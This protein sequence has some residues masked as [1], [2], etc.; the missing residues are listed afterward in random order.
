MEEF[1]KDNNIMSG[2]GE[3]DIDWITVKGSHIPLKDGQ[4]SKEAIQQHF[5]NQTT[6][7]DAIGHLVNTLKKIKNIKLK[8][9]HTFIKSL[10]PIS[11]RMNGD[12]IIAEFDK[13]TADKN[14][15]G[16]GKSDKAG[17]DY[18]IN[19]PQELPLMIK[20]S[21]YSYSK[22]EIG[23]KKPAH[24]GVK[25]WH[26]FQKDYGNFNVVVNVRD[27]GNRKFVYEVILKKKKV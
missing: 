18:K 16:H 27:K 4:T 14:V 15:Y 23:K 2:K 10:E 13:F 5:G 26:Y 7:K 21:K 24:S 20:Q 11:L 9:I 17:Y 19:N 1:K 12:E 25:E 8:E 22:P 3:N 6:K